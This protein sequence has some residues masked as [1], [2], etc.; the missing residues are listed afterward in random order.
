MSNEY[1]YEYELCE[2]MDKIGEPTQTENL[3]GFNILFW[4]TEAVGGLLIILV[5]IWTAHYRGGFSWTSNPGLEFNWHPLLMT[6]GLVFLYANGMLIYR[7]QRQIRKRRL[8]LIH[9]GIMIFAVLLTVVALVAVFDSHNLNKKDGVLSP[10][11]NMYTL[12]SWVG[13]TSVI[14]FCCQWLAGFL[15]FLYPMAQPSLRGAYLPVHVYFG[16]AAFIG[17]IAACLMGLTEKAFFALQSSYAELPGEAV[18]V[19][20]IGLVFVIFGGLTVY[21]VSQ[22]RYRR[23][24]RPEDDILLTGRNE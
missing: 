11:P 7:S 22:E 15:S 14:L 16:T 13:L 23:L 9:S 2:D 8:K 1:P 5:A 18:L 21:I 3:E 12:H 19:N 24:P 4:T 10:I 20:I 6:I 17:T